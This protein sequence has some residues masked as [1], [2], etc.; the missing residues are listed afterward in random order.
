MAIDVISRAVATR[1]LKIALAGQ[2]NV[3]KSTVFNMLTGL[4]QHVGN[5]PGKTVEMKA[6]GLEHHGVSIDVVDLPGTYSLTA[7]SPEEIVAR[8]YILTEEPDVVMVVINA[9]SLERNLYLVAEL[10]ALSCPLV[11]GLNMM[12]VAAREGYA[13]RP[14][15]LSEAIGVPVVP[16]TAARGEGVHDLLDEAIQVA[17]SGGVQDAHRPEIREDHRAILV[18]V[19]GLIDGFVPGRYPADWVAL[20]LLE[21]DQE[22]TALMHGRLPVPSW[23]GLQSVLRAHEDAIV[24]VASGRYAWISQVAQRAMTRPRAG[25]VTITQRIDDYA[26]HPFWGLIVLALVMGVIFGLTY[27]VGGPLQGWIESAMMMPLSEWLAQALAGTPGWIGGLII[28]GVMGGVGTMLTFLPIL[29]LFFAGMGFLEDV[30]Y[31]ARAAYVMDRFMHGIGLH[32]KSFMPLFLGF[33]CNVP[34]IMGARILDS[35][36]DRILTIM[37]APLVPCAA[38]LA[39]L[40]VLAQA[41][42]PENALAVTWGLTALPLIVLAVA[43]LIARGVFL[44]DAQSA[45]IMELPLYHLPSW[46]T[47]GLTVWQR[48]VAFLKKAGTVILAVSIVI[49]ALVS[50]PGDTIESSFL[51]MLGRLIEPIGRLMGMG[52]R[53]MVAILSSFVAKE[54]AVATLGVLYGVGEHAGGLSALMGTEFSPASALAFLV[55]EMLFIPCVSTL[56]VIRQETGTWKWVWVNVAFLGLLA[57]MG[58]VVAY[59]LASLW[60]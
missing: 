28:E 20:K 10:L 33:G 19:Q 50:Y 30:G 29:A 32:G 26:T 25:H 9:A 35:P 54:N 14:R 2:P 11:I 13:I 22:I 15:D 51:A 44:R 43:G 16:M 46:R 36:R 27:A 1:T 38:R 42:F 18:Q 56:A 6:G 17:R 23:E 39:V 3:G 57:F 45:F 49:W 60:L 41:F 37:L 8:E 47:I 53:P 24:A 48:T 21:G 5:W 52:W 55:V 12:D 34:A 7:S 4:N 59:H 58:G 40:T 31:M